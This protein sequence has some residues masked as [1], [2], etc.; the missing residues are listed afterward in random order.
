M[1]PPIVPPPPGTA[2]TM[3]ESYSEGGRPLIDP[4]LSWASLLAA[5]RV[6]YGATIIVPIFVRTPKA[7]AVAV[8]PPLPPI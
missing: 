6:P 3:P 8:A 5:Q 1:V 7:L 4:V 2:I